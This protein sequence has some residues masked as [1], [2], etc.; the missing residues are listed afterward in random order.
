MMSISLFISLLLLT[1]SIQGFILS[2]NLISLPKGNRSANL[3]LGSLIITFSIII[4]LHSGFE[5]N[6]PVSVHQH[7]YLCQIFQLL[8]GPLI[9]LY[10]RS[11]TDFKTPDRKD[12]FHVLP[13]LILLISGIIKSLFPTGPLINNLFGPLIVTVLSMQMASYLLLSLIK[14]NQYQRRIV[15][16]F[17]SIEKIN[18]N[19]LKFLV[20][21]NMIIWPS[22]LIFEIVD[23]GKDYWNLVL[24]LVSVFIYMV[25]YKGL[26]QPEIFRVSAEIL[27]IFVSPRKKYE[28]SSLTKEKADAIF[29]ELTCFMN[30]SKPY[31][32]SDLSL[33]GLA[34]KVCISPHHVSQI[35][36]EK[37][38]K[39]FYEY[40]NEYRVSEAQKYLIDPR[41]QTCTIASIGFE[42][43]FNSVS[44]FN[45]IFKKIT[46]MTPSQ[47]R[48]TAAISKIPA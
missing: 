26:R 7:E 34:K 18:L 36:N 32:S 45:S 38:N 44:S 15:S 48:K 39:N 25:G 3:L 19:W 16:N 35:I 42:A 22:A 14:L 1:S 12:L 10:V 29:A 6:L 17:S 13:S 46:S 43:G 41:K 33:N 20:W 37:L 8:T 11:R 40:V 21:T 5:L 9:F 27:P 47:Y 23:S 30:S 28:K 31:L 24:L 4:L 2:G